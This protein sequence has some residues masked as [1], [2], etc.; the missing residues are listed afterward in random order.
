MIVILNEN[1]RGVVSDEE[2]M[3]SVLQTSLPNCVGIE[4]SKFTGD[5][6]KHLKELKPDLV[7]QNSLLGK[8]SEFKT[9]TYLQDNFLEMRRIL[10]RSLIR[11]LIA[12][13]IGRNDFYST[14]I[15]KQIEVLRS[16]IRV[17]NSNYTANSYRTV[18]DFHIIPIG[19]NTDLFR[20]MDK[21]EMR[22][23]YQIP[24]DRQVK[25]FVGSQH[26]VKGFDAIKRMIYDD[27]NVFWILVFKDSPI[28]D[29]HNFKV[30]CRVSQTTLAELYNCADIFVGRSLVETLGLAAIEA[31]FCDIPVDVTP[32]GIF[33]DW[34]PDNNQ[35]RN[36]A[37]KKGLDRE[38]MI[39]K[40]RI[41]IEKYQN[42]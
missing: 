4:L 8:L 1:I 13:V 2:T 36:E 15:R 17:A 39:K 6:N 25:I 18:G 7:I 33:W 24:I 9:I 5:I 10:G 3:W 28:E 20:P 32:T 16:S 19:V 40:W 22:K 38:T 26:L 35:P 29:G 34:T 27:S 23:K 30:F 14:M 37:F 31:M 41:L 42:E 21:V 12:R 11:R